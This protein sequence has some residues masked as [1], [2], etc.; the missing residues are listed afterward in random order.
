M[1]EILRFIGWFA[2]T[3]LRKPE[4]VGIVFGGLTAL[5]IFIIGITNVEIIGGGFLAFVVVAILAG[6][7][8]AIGGLAIY[9]AIGAAFYYGREIWQAYR[10]DY[11][12]R[13]RKQKAP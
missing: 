12:A 6:L 4:S 9:A 2:K 1:S 11:P 10:K 7:F 5:V 3:Y 8:A 13:K